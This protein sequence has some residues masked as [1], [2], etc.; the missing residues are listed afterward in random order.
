VYR[1]RLLAEIFRPAAMVE[2]LFTS[3]QVITVPQSGPLL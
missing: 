1:S 2:S 3:K